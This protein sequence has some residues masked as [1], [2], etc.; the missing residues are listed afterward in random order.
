MIKKTIIAGVI[1]GC[2]IIT[3]AGCGSPNNDI[4]VRKIPDQE[5]V[6]V[7]HVENGKAT[8]TSYWVRT[9]YFTSVKTGDVFEPHYKMAEGVPQYTTTE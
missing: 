4:I 6:W 8:I 3:F 1:L 9:D 2:S 5:E 7:K